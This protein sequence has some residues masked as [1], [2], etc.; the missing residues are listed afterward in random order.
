[1]RPR[2]S[3]AVLESARGLFLAKG[4]EA[5]TVDEIADRAHVSKAT[6]YSNFPDKAALLTSLLD[7]VAVESA[8]ILARVV[9]PLDG[10]GSVEDRVV[11]TAV[12]LARG[13]LRPEVLQ[14]RRLAVAESTRFPAAV[15]DWFERGPGSSLRLLAASFDA[16]ARRGLLVLDDPDDAAARF[17]YAVVGPLQDRA[18]LTGTAPA[19]AEVVRFATAAAAAFLAAHRGGDAD[20]R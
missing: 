7:R 18:L 10:P 8:A 20:D 1:M 12:A 17:A 6:V 3:E 16:M 19:D 11:D 4:F 9:A 15:A 5:T 2:K 14:L 13:V